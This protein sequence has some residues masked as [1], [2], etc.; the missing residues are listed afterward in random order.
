MA[1]KGMAQ[2][3][4]NLNRTLLH[5]VS[6][7]AEA[8]MHVATSIVGGYATLMTPVDTSVL[9]NSQYRR[10]TTERGR[11]V[12][13]IGYTAQYAA[14]VHDKTGKLKGQPRYNGRGNYWDP[15]AEPK[16]LSKA[17]DDNIGE[18]DSAV[19]RAMQI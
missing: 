2:V 1:I 10:V 5:V 19:T 13:V 16:F 3:R 14:A 15:D 4:R 18:I 17:G 6:D 8:A 7:K 12:A 9:I 11:V